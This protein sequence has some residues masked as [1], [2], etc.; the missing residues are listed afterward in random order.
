M[1]GASKP[2]WAA[3]RNPGS[4]RGVPF[5]VLENN[6]RRGRQ[7]SLHTYPFRDDPWPEDLGRSS[8]VTSFRGFVV[9]D[10]CDTQIK[11]LIDAVEM[12]GPGPL[13]HPTFGSINATVIAFAAADEAER[14]RMW[15]FEMSVVPYTSR[16]YPVAAANTQGAAGGLFGSFGAEL[17]KDF[18]AVKAKVDEVRSAVGGV[19][20]TVQGYVAQA[21]GLIGDA[22]SLAR[23]PTQILGNFGRFAGGG[24]SINVPGLSVLNTFT[25][26]SNSVTSGFATASRIGTTLTG[27]ASHL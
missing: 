22:T 19:V 6:I 20:S 5:V 3:L 7:V 9:G 27:L 25:T 8:R 14:G 17:Q 18:A 15:S 10:D 11:N 23:I 16:I 4:F 2:Q 26:V 1:A 24:L 21:N 13:L 12:P